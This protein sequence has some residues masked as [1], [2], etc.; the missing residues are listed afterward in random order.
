MPDETSPE[1]DDSTEERIT[2]YLTPF[3]Q[4]Y[5][6]AMLWANTS[7]TEDTEGTGNGPDVYAWQDSSALW[8][9]DAFTA[10]S[11]GSI[12]EDC[13][14]FVRACWPDLESVEAKESAEQAGHDFALTRNHHGAG[15]WDRGLDDAGRRL[16]DA[17]HAYGESTAYLSRDEYDNGGCS[18]VHLDSE[19]V[20]A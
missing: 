5:A 3:I 13:E 16:T 20:S 8:A 6:V 9:L 11:Q 19:Q 10:V 4:G 2:E 14:A 1:Y 15:Y 12:R 18:I 7:F 17:A